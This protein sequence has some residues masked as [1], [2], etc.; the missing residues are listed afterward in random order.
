MGKKNRGN[1][2]ESKAPTSHQPKIHKQ[3]PEKAVKGR[4]GVEQKTKG[5]SLFQIVPDNDGEDAFAAL[6]YDKE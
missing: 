5:K 1:K 4:T 2:F 6:G 3:Q